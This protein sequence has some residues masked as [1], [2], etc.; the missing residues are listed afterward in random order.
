[1]AM[2]LFLIIVAIVLGLVGVVAHGV[3]YLLFI[4]IAVLVVALLISAVRFRRGGR[5][6]NR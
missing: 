5:S 2:V 6:P 3:L 1:M 4:G